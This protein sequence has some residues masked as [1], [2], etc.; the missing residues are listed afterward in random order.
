VVEK[1]NDPLTHLIRNALDH[2]IES[3]EVRV[4]NGKPAKGSVSLNAYHDSGHIVVEIRDDGAGLDPERIRQRAIEKGMIRAD[5]VLSREETF[6][7]IFE[8]GLSTKG[9]ASNLSGRGVGMDVVR[10]NI[11]ALRG[12]VELDSEKGK[13]TTVTIILPL[14]L[15]IIDGFLV[16]SGRE[17][18]VIPLAQVVECVE[19]N[20][21]NDVERQGHRYINLRGEVLPYLHLKSF[22]GQV[23]AAANDDNGVHEILVVV[24]FGHQKAGLVVDQLHGELQTVIKPMGVIFEQLRGVAGAT[25]LGTGDIALILDVQALTASVNAS[26]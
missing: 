2:G 20:E 1:I 13:G 14:T 24:R 16:G 6:R 3:P 21:A 23:P 12:S 19:M 15:A 18:Y 10:R 26:Q 25:V 7:L 5:Q 8:P 17:Q 22:F 11:E 9:E 4:A